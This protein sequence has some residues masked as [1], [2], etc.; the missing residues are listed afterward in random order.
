MAT[1]DSE[2]RLKFSDGIVR[3]R[4]IDMSHWATPDARHLDVDAIVFSSDVFT[5]GA[6]LECSGASIHIPQAI[7]ITGFGDYDF[8]SQLHPGLTTVGIPLGRSGRH[9][10]AAD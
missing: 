9:L 7:A 1:D 2:E 3:G 6:L 4:A 8:A 10:P 5:G